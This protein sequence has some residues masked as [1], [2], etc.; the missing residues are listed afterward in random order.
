MSTPVEYLQKHQDTFKEELFDLLRIPSISADPNHKKDVR[1][2][3]EFVAGQLEKIGLNNVSIEET[4]GHPI[5]QSQE[6]C[7]ARGRIRGRAA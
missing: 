1:R 7:A 5:S 6:R 2:A 3:A 4:E